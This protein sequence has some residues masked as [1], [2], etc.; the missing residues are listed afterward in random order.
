MADASTYPILVSLPQ[1]REVNRWWGLLWLGML[2]RAI[3]AIPHLIVLMVLTLLVGLGSLIVWIPILVNGRV[4]A[5]WCKVV[6]EAIARQTRV[7]AYLYLFPGGYP[8]LEM[9]GEGPVAVSIDN[10]DRSINRWWG[11]PIIGML[12]RW[13]VLIPQAIVLY[14]LSLIVSLV[15]LV[16]WIPILVNGR[17]PELGMKLV[18]MYLKYSA[19]VS[20]YGAFLPVPYPPIG[21]L[22]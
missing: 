1:E 8:A 6:G 5:L 10:G 16:I 20:G 11:I 21:D 15:G 4:P 9:G 14:V 13:I 19:R 3:L 12:V 17:Y 22:G 18:G 7:N 2:V